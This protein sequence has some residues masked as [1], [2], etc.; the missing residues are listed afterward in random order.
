MKLHILIILFI[1]TFTNLSICQTQLCG[2]TNPTNPITENAL[3]KRSSQVSIPVFFHIILSTSGE[4]DVSDSQI[5]QQITVINEYYAESNYLFYLAGVTKTRNNSWRDVVKLSQNEIDMKNSLGVDPTHVLNIYVTSTIDFLGWAYFPEDYSENSLQHG[6]VVRTDCLPNGSYTDYNYGRIAAHETGHYLGLLHTFG[7]SCNKDAD[8]ISDT[9]IHYMNQNCPSDNTNTCS[10]SPGNDPVHN[11]MNYTN[12]PCRWDITWGQT[13]RVNSITGQFRGNLG[14]TDIYINSSRT[15]NS[16]DTWKI[17]SGNYFLGSNVSIIV[18]GTLYVIGNSSS[19]ITFTKSGSSNWGGFQFNSGSIGNLQYCNIQNAVNGIY[20]YNSSP[21]INHSTIDNNSSTGLYC[22]Y[23]SSPVLVGNN[24][25]FNGQ[26]GVR[27]NLYS[28]PHLTDNG[29]SGANIIRNNGVGVYANYYS[30][31]YLPGYQTT[32]N[33]IFD[34]NGWE[35][36]A[37]LYSTVNAQ[38]VFW[39]DGATTYVMGGSTIDNSNPLYSNPNSGRKI[40]ADNSSN[41]TNQAISLK[42]VADDL[43]SAI[44]KQKD[45]KYDEAIP[46]FLEVFKNNKDV[47][48]GR[49]ALCKIEECFTQAG[50][51]DY[52]YYSKKEIKPLLKEGSE[53]YV[54]ALELETHQMVNAGLYIEAIAVLQTILKKYN[55]N[56]AIEK[57]TLF[58]LGAF[59]TI[60]LGDRTSSDS[61][62]AELKRKFPKDD[63]VNQIEIVKG[64]GLASR[65]TVQGSNEFIPAEETPQI[66]NAGVQE[67]VTNYPN[68]FNPSTQ[69][70]F[71]LKESGKVSLK[72]YD[73]LGKEVAN[74]ADGYYEAGKHTA[75]FDGSSAIGGLAS[76]IYFY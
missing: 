51:K 61:Y 10:N 25:R 9:P 15:I 41:S 1:F 30:N 27:C 69:I 76:G 46:L 58:S 26:Y 53:V 12:D 36:A 6:V 63:L 5:N 28:S 34:N 64:L 42:V 62:F 7:D 52:L 32:G 17:V 23:Y 44:D 65:N 8:L 40:L 75:A 66:A 14:G 21:T 50:K 59:Y 54:A 19:N 57:N 45:K 20:C 16:N 38:R 43:A 72:V 67:E 56:E 39:G 22:D 35:L 3:F 49:Y 4:G 55:L 2:T 33:S 70:R 68:P 13:S 37:M 60:F 47:L 71:T 73:V 74:L 29:A 31:P 18:N 24:F 11:I 48:L